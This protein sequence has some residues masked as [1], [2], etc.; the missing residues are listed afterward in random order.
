WPFAARRQVDGVVAPAAPGIKHGRVVAIS[1]RQQLAGQREALR[2]GGQRRAR[3][4]F[5]LHHAGSSGRSGGTQR[6]ATWAG[7]CAVRSFSRTP[8]VAFA[9]LTTPGTPAPGC[10]PAPTM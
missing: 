2:T 10:V 6:P 9:E 7:A 1:A 8:T 4:A 3:R 5:R